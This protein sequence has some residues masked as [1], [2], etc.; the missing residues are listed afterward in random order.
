MK[1]KVKFKKATPVNKYFVYFDIESGQ[2]I[3]ITNKKQDN[4]DVYF[5]VP[6]QEVEDFLIGTRNLTKHRV[7]FDVKEQRYQIVSDQ[8]SI[9]VYADDLI[10]R[11][12]QNQAAQVIV[13]QD[14]INKKWKIYA[15]DEIKESMASIGARL[16]EVMFFSITEHGNPNILYNY[17][18]V[19]MKDIVEEPFVEFPFVSQEEE[20]SKEIS[21][22]TNRKFDR[23]THEVINE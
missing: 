23:Y 6:I 8:E 15:S 17:F 14:L 20:N 16:E 13:D 21:V 9:I 10:F 1:Y 19:S 7:I 5:E 4:N 2:I 11:I 18:Y 22:Y 3:S 12:Q